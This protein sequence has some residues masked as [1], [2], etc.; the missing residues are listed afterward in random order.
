MRSKIDFPLYITKKR[1][2]NDGVFD[3]WLS[4]RTRFQFLNIG[5]HVQTAFFL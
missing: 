3:Y 1:R 4:V 2:L 5:D